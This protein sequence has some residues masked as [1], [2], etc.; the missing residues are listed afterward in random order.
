[1]EKNI[2]IKIVYMYIMS[3]FAVQQRSAQHCKS[4]FYISIKKRMSFDFRG[5]DRMNINMK[6]LRQ[7]KCKNKITI[8]I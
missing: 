2:K 5:N 3:H 4:S 7:G 1:M 6:K 8:S